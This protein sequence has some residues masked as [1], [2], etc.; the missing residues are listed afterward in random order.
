MHDTP[1]VTVVIPAHNEERYIESTIASIYAQEYLTE[2]VEI[3][4]V[5]NNSSDNTGALAKKSGANVLFCPSG[6]VGAV[7]NLGA[8]NSQN[9]IIAFIDGDCEAAPLWLSAAVLKLSDPSVGAVGGPCLL[10]KE[11][12]WV[13][14][15]FVGPPIHREGETSRLAGSSLIMRRKDFESIG[16]FSETLSAGED[17]ELSA[18]VRAQGFKVLTLA[19]CSVIHNG[20]PKSLSQIF[21]KQLW[22]A[23]NQ[24]ET[25]ESWRDSTLIVTHLFTLNAACLLAT[26]V[27]A[28]IRNPILSSAFLGAEIILAV[29]L[30]AVKTR[31]TGGGIRRLVPLTAINIVYLSARAV[32]LIGNY[33]RKLKNI[34]SPDKS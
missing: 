24:L 21:R 23:K 18:R 27:F 8:A 29:L 32:A 6:K 4:V 19:N 28:P 22:H 13:E 14:A 16:G 30:A 31:R 9:A 12:T 11:T 3:F 33:W 5:D 20:Y 10:P 1:S 7:R 34:L 17:D 15:A 2:K 25:A 26:E